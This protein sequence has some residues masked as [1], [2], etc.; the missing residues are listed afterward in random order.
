MDDIQNPFS[1]GAG[2]PPPE[3][4]GRDPVLDEA[5]ALLGRV[6]RKKSAQSMLL[7]GLRGVGKTVLLNEMERLAIK[8]GYKTIFI[9]AHESKPLG[10]LLAPHLWKLLFDLDRMAGI[11]NKVKRGLAVLQSFI[12]G[13]RITVNEV[14]IGLDIDPER[15]SADSGDLEI[16]LPNLFVAIAE[17]AEDRK[18]PV[19]ILID[20][21]Q[22]LSQKELGALIMAMHK[23][24]QRQLP[25]VLL[26]AGLPTL[27][28]LAGDSK[29]YS[30]RLFS[31]PDIGALSESDAFRALKD[32]AQ[33][34]GVVF[35]LDALEEIF[36]LTKGYP[37]FLQEWGY[38]TWNH[39]KGSPINLQTVRNA[40]DLVVK[41]LDKNFFRVRFDRLIPSEKTFLRQMAKLG[42][43]PY[44]SGDI[45][46][47]LKRS[48]SSTA[49]VRAKL[50]KKG[51]IYSPAHGEL[52]FTVP[53]FDEFLARAI[54]EENLL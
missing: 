53:L 11:G 7:T 39:A 27:P 49:P 34:E 26:G 15:G 45:A 50:M 12:S 41:R 30:E 43:G 2:A 33:E 28:A 4:V 8:D 6:K 3:L 10:P 36:R 13:L 17:A 29:S 42:S 14:T 44:K 22:Y 1:P 31:F 9:E 52:A 54:P 46:D 47:L 5:R 18:S 25:L 51:M 40:T 23:I 19:A 16:D 35:D 20:E 32:P 21:I 24:Q 38:Q 48:T 37:Y